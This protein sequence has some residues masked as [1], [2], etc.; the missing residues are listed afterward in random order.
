MAV[1]SLKIH[2]WF[3]SCMGR[4]IIWLLEDST[5]PAVCCNP[6]F[7]WPGLNN[8]LTK[9]SFLFLRDMF[10]LAKSLCALGEFSCL[11]LRKAYQEF[12]DDLAQTFKP[13]PFWT[14]ALCSCGI[15]L[16]V[17]AGHWFQ[18]FWQ[19][20]NYLAIFVPIALQ[21]AGSTSSNKLAMTHGLW[22]LQSSKRGNIFLFL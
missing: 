3:L 10:S 18:T 11:L 2:F 17:T 6:R 19:N 1:F 16:L 8:T 4:D 12:H 22:N 20:G 15:W 9:E 13:L 5:E 21:T 7:T 14:F